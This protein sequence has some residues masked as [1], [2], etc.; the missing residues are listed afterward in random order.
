MRPSLGQLEKVSLMPQDNYTAEKG[1]VHT[2]T[3]EQSQ[4]RKRYVGKGHYRR[5]K[6]KKKVLK[7]VC[8]CVVY[9]YTHILYGENNDI[10]MNIKICSC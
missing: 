5:K 6:K 7:G 9:T 4:S 8:V 3:I 10:H 2:F 1:A